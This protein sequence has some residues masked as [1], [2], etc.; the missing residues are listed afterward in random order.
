M[1]L[2]LSVGLELFRHEEPFL[3][4]IIHQLISLLGLLLRLK[5]LHTVQNL[6]YD[7]SKRVNIAFGIVMILLLFVD[8]RGAVRESVS[9]SMFWVSKCVLSSQTSGW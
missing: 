2:R 5:R 9:G 8:L 4:M 1:N 3:H 7:D 6:V